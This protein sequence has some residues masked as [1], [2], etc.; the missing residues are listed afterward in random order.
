M[1]TAL[2]TN[3]RQNVDGWCALI[4]GGMHEICI[5]FQELNVLP[6][7]N[8][9]RKA[10]ILK[11]LLGKWMSHMRFYQENKEDVIQQ[12]AQLTISKYRPFK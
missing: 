9:L 6:D 11:K 7:K 8:M 12:N 1:A 2:S 10:L 5:V 3:F 4:C